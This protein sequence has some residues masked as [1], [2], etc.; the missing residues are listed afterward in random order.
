V[1]VAVAVRAITSK[2]VVTHYRRFAESR[3]SVVSAR[4]DV[5]LRYH[6]GGSHNNATTTTTT[7]KHRRPQFAVDT[8]LIELF[9]PRVMTSHI[10]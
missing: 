5:T 6:V 9:F 2:P 1:A 10:Y 3:K 8:R 7:G 4:A